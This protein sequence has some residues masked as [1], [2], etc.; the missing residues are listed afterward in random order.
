M[1]KKL[2][3]LL[4]MISVTLIQSQTKKITGTVSDGDVGLPGATIVVKGTTNGTNTDF[5]GKY[6]IKAQVGDVLVFSY[7]GYKTVE[8]TVGT[9]S[10]VNVIMEESEAVL[11]E[12]A[13]TSHGVSKVSGYTSGLTV[14]KKSKRKGSS[15]DGIKIP[16]P[17]SGQLTAAEINDIEK[18]EDWKKL[19]SRDDFEQVKKDWKFDLGEKLTVYV[20]DDYN[21]PIIN[22]VVILVDQEGNI[23]QGKTDI[24][25]KVLFYKN[26]SNYYIV[27]VIHNG[28]IKGSR[29]KSKSSNITFKFKN[30]SNNDYSLDLMFT[31]DATGSMSDEIQYLKSELENI[32]TRI[33]S[34]ITSKRIALTF[35]RDVNDDFLVRDFDFSSNIKDVKKNLLKQHANGGGDYEEAVEVALEKSLAMSWRDNATARLMFLLL[36]APPHLND[37]NVKMIKNQIKEAKKKGIKII[38]IVASGANKNVE[39]LMRY[40]SVYTDGTY[41]FLTDDSGIGNTHLKP[42][43]DDYKVEKLNDLIVRLI[44]AHAK[45]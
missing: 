37:E 35:Y 21:Q 42:T 45:A 38:P 3:T 41:V 22:A 20:K 2:L 23:S 29:Y 25:G 19:I 26:Q 34:S 32:I 5:E 17:Q 18:W 44:N 14:S 7:L 39:Y 27:Q 6:E 11:E 43:A 28:K 9:S 31:V 13:I 4:M 1:R 10:V 40:F 15:R 16:R 36:D 24:K 33:D 30:P 8:M 12:I